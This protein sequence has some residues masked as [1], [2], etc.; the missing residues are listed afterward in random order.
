M[1]TYQVFWLWF[2]GL[3][4]LAAGLI[5]VGRDFVAASGLDRWIRLGPV[6]VAAPL[7]VF[8]AEHFVAAKTM[9]QMVPAWLP[10]R[11]FWAYF[12]GGAWLAAAISLVAKRFVRLSATLLG[13]MFLLIVLT[14][15][16]PNAISDPRDRLGW[17]VVLRETAFAGGAWALAGGG[18]RKWMTLFG[19]FSLAIAVIYFG[20]DEVLHPAL[21]PGVP[22]TKMTPAWVPLH[23][24]WGYPVG[25]FL[26]AAGAALLL[27]IRPRTAA[28]SIGVLM[29]LLTAA[30]FLPILILTADPSQMTEAINFVADTLLF[31]GT[32]LLVAGALP[33]DRN[34]SRI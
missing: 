5:A 2:A 6:F 23:A 18:K 15:H 29:T 16:L 22:D 7:A 4:F 13:V 9:A 25:A 10:A 28:V 8:A 17:I 26:I 32:A 20:L 24:L 1:F 34:T 21:T 12:V 31:G 30:L 19:R 11:L 27:N 33:A 3:V 14:I